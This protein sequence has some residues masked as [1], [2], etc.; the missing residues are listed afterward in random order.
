[1]SDSN[2][3]IPI[4]NDKLT[5]DMYYVH[6]LCRS[7][8]LYNSGSTRIIREIYE[9]SS[10]RSTWVGLVGKP[11]YLGSRSEYPIKPLI[12]I[13]AAR[14]SSTSSSSRASSQSAT[15]S[16]STTTTGSGGGGR[17][18]KDWTLIPCPRFILYQPYHTKTQT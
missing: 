14:T 2:Q 16:T 12:S 3:F 17:R 7:C 5:S 1:M 18:E 8:R 10:M 15:S 13:G 6:Q 11:V 9:L 4:N